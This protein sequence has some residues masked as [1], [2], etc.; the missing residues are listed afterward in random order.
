HIEFADVI[1][2]TRQAQNDF[3]TVI[4]PHRAALWKYCRY[5]TGSPWDGE[6]LFQQTLLKA[7]AALSQ[8]WQ[9]VVPKTYLFRIASHTWIDHC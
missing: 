1:Q 2:R 4:E 3:L 7:Y 8:M 6:D 5:L 9:P